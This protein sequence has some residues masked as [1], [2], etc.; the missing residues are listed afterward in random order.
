MFRFKVDIIEALAS[1][2]SP[3]ATEAYWAAIA[4]RA[5]DEMA[6]EAEA[7]EAKAIE[8]EA[9][10]R[11]TLGWD[12]DGFLGRGRDHALR[13]RV[14]GNRQRVARDRAARRRG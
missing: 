12:S 11:A 4:E 7:I 6:L 9:A 8:A 3:E 2:V 1:M 5:D 14:P 13:P 10:R